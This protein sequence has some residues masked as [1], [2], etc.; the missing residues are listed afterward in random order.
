MSFQPFGELGEKCYFGDRGKGTQ[1]VSRKSSRINLMS[2]GPDPG[3]EKGKYAT[4]SRRCGVV[5]FDHGLKTNRTGRAQVS[6]GGKG[7]N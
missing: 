6:N 3:D 7:K 1:K 5:I 4:S 2:K